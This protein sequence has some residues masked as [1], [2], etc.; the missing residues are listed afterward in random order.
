MTLIANMVLSKFSVANITI[1]LATTTNI[2]LTGSQIIDGK[3]VSA[4]DMILVKDQTNAVENGI[5]EVSSSGAWAR[6]TSY[7]TGEKIGKRIFNIQDGTVNK[8][9]MFFPIKDSY[10]IDEEEIFFTEY[11][12]SIS[13]LP[14]KIPMRDSAGH[15]K[16]SSASSGNDCVIKSD[17][18][19]LIYPV[20]SL[21]W[22]SKSTD[23][24]ELFGGTWTRIKDCFVWAKGDS[25]TVNATGGS[26]TVTLE[27]SNIPLH[28]HNFTPSGS[29]TLSSHN[30]YFSH[31]HSFLPEGSVGVSISFNTMTGTITGAGSSY[32][33]DG[34]NNEIFASA[35]GVFSVSGTSK[36][37]GLGITNGLNYKSVGGTRQ[38][39][40]FEATPSI[41]SISTS[42]SGTSKYTGWSED[43]YTGYA[44]PT[45]SLTGTEGTTS[46]YG[47]DGN[48]N[49]SPI[50]L[51]PPYVVKYCFER[52]S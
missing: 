44:S 52:I 43:D 17:L 11:Y 47:G 7:N 18:L 16:S 31:R 26:K 1:N 3:T 50:N 33:N 21:Y 30:H 51:L 42:F 28:S 46:T 10:V 24:R 13:P 39:V 35:S 34:S 37:F 9:K 8:G 48:G 40:T 6:N 41:S 45:A 29:V 49:T 14:N 20:G 27:T 12:G 32:I 25:D 15:V 23:P 4:G 22:S 36:Q 38:S 19:N 2:A 5:Y